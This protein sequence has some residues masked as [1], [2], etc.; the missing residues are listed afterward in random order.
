MTIVTGREKLK[1]IE[2]EVKEGKIEKADT[3]SF[4]GIML[5]QEGDLKDHIKKTESKANKIIREINEISS[6]QK[7]GQ[8]DI[9][10]IIKLF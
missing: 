9:W 8:E 10:V 3:Y 2:E 5:K 6:K 7:V 4:F 1:Q